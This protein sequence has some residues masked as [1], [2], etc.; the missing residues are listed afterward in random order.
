MVGS[1]DRVGAGGDNAAME[2]FFSLLQN[3]VNRR[4][5]TTREVLRIAIVTC[6]ERSY[7]RRRQ[8][9]LGRLVPVE[10]ELIM[11]QPPPRRPNRPVTHS[12]S[13][14]LGCLDDRV[15]N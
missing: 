9:G 14:T 15:R 5:G 12:C 6:I 11:T 4:S 10:Y 7:R 13:R 2:Y 3:V 1:M 8:A